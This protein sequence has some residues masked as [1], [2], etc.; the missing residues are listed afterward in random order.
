M[1]C[2][3]G[4]GV[5]IL[6]PLTNGLSFGRLNTK[7]VNKNER[8]IFNSVGNVS[9][10]KVPKPG[11]FIGHDYFHSNPAV[12]SDLI[13]LIL[14]KAAPGSKERPLKNIENNFWS[15]DSDYLIEK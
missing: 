3:K 15:L 1:K 7:D 14:H 6:L 12:S 2:L 8:N 9:L 5:L 11:S 10:I 4:L 13:N